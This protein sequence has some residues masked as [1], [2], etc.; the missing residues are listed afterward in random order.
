MLTPAL[1]VRL[2]TYRFY[3][4]L[5]PLDGM[6]RICKMIQRVNQAFSLQ[7]RFILSKR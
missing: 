1:V 4:N 2:A 5:R 3:S 6:N 7:F